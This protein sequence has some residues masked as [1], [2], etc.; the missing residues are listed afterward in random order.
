MIF[1]AQRNFPNA[2]ERNFTS[3]QFI[4]QV[5][6]IFLN[7]IFLER[8]FLQCN[9]FK[10]RNLFLDSQVPI[11]AKTIFNFLPQ[12]FVFFF[13]FVSNCRITNFRKFLQMKGCINQ[14]LRFCFSFF[15]FRNECLPIFYT[16]N[17]ST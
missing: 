15:F 8:N 5:M 6:N 2:T 16:T 9:F 10:I 1:R 7:A 13:Q 3:T 4:F 12:K 17:N 11:S 14:F